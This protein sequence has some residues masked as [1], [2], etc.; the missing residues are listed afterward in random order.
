MIERALHR[1]VH[2][3]SMAALFFLGCRIVGGA[4]TPAGATVYGIPFA[5]LATV[6]MIKSGWYFCE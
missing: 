5:I 6:T 3:V 2:V 1:V 4:M